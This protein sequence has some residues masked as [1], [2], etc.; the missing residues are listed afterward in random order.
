[1]RRRP[2]RLSSPIVRRRLAVGL[3]VAG[4]V[5]AGLGAARR[6]ASSDA[7]SSTY[8]FDSVGLLIVIVGAVL[9][10]MTAQLFLLVAP[11]PARRRAIAL[12]G[13]GVVG[14]ITSCLLLSTAFDAN[15]P[16]PLAGVTSAIMVAGVGA[17]VGGLFSLLVFHGSD[18]AA[19]R[20]NE[21]S[22]DEW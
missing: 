18:Y 17:F 5:V 8:L 4:G 15:A 10:V 1:M 3:I 20:I 12:T 21:M 2:R 6:A 7:P 14:A 11:A 13:G 19:R 22:Q 9:E 16:W